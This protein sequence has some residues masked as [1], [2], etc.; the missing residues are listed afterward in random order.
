MAPV[1]QERHVDWQHAFAV[2][3]VVAETRVFLVAGLQADRLFG[4]LQ[5]SAA[6]RKAAS[7]ASGRAQLYAAQHVR[8][9]TG[10]HNFGSLAS[11]R[12]QGR[13]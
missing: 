12:A 1:R 13:Q 6:G 7:K 4:D 11:R 10:I 5:I 2:L 3:D 8:A 9:A